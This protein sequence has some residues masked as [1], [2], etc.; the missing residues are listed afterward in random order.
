MK[1]VNI[2]G[3]VVSCFSM[4][5]L[6][7]N[8]FADSSILGSYG[9]NGGWDD[10]GLPDYNHLIPSVVEW[11]YNP[12]VVPEPI[13]SILFLVGSAMFGIRQWSKR[14]TVYLN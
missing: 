2:I 8:V 12:T 6:A 13:S 10:F 4:I 1:K 5:L 9:H 7:N 3:I 14:S 11:N